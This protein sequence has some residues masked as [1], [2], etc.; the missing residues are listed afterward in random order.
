MFEMATPAEEPNHIIDPPKPTA[1]A[2]TPQSYP[3]CARASAV[4][5]MLSNTAE[6]KPRP[7]VV[8]QLAGGRLSTGISDADITRQS[9]NNVPFS[10]DPMIAQ[11]GLRS[12]AVTMIA[13]QTPMP[14][15]GSMSSSSGK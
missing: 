9:R 2:S 13:A 11:S 1:K 5:G 7:M 4:S 14:I 12:S 3:P 8:G 6:T 15:T 10:D